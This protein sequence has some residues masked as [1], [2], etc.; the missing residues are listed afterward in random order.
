MGLRQEQLAD[1]IRDIIA[2][3]LS[4]GQISDPRLEGVGI[5][6]VKLTGDLQLASIYF[7]CYS[8]RPQ[9]EI[10]KGLKSAAGLMRHHLAKGLGVRKIP[11]LRFF[12]DE[13]IERGSKIEEL[14]KKI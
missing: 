4:G 5:T 13:S 14:L 8:E 7:R 11:G 2:T 12:Y 9:E 6:A 10:Q 1:Q 3:L